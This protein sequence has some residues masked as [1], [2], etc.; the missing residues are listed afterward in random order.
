MTLT[1]KKGERREV[2]VRLD[3]EIDHHTA[4]GIRAAIDK[5]IGEEKPSVV[6]IDFSAV[7]FMDS[8]GIGL[9]IGRV[10]AAERIG[11]VVEI[12]GLSDTQRR[13]ARMAGLE[14]LSGLIIL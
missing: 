11:A 10:G 9:I 12:S 14:K 13:L 3:T 2:R 7:E 6:A 1:L 4:V 8:S 5:A